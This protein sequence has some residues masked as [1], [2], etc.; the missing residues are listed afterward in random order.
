MAR[1]NVTKVFNL[2]LNY[3]SGNGD[4][5]AT[6]WT[7]GTTIYSYRLPLVTRTMGR[8]WIAEGGRSLYTQTT[9]IHRNNLDTLIALQHLDR[10]NVI[11]KV[12]TDVL[13][14]LVGAH[15]DERESVIAETVDAVEAPS[16]RFAP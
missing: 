10:S 16:V 9:T 14:R 4:S 6:V 15:E 3:K 5:K 12:K 8:I 7:D 2:W 1:K 11:H 13:R